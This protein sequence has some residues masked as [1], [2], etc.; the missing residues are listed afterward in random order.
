MSYMPHFMVI[1][2]TKQSKE[3]VI[4]NFVG[5]EQLIYEVQPT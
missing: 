2:K 5:F 4:E 3:K 1:N